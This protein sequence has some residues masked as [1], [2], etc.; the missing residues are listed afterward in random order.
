[1]RKVFWWIWVI[2]FLLATYGIFT[3]AYLIGR[4]NTWAEFAQSGVT[5]RAKVVDKHKDDTYYWLTYEFKVHA[6]EEDLFFRKTEAVSPEIYNLLEIGA[7]LKSQYLFDEPGTVRLL[8]KDSLGNLFFWTV[9]GMLTGVASL[10]GLMR[11]FGLTIR[12]EQPPFKKTLVKPREPEISDQSTPPPTF[13]QCP[14][15]QARNEP[16]AQ[17]CG[18]CGTK[19]QP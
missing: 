10:F 15:C 9:L 19:L 14:N 2:I 16:T 7:Q 5:T 8:G 13:I 11:A 4:W 6:D 12:Q 17:F 18:E 1:M 3:R